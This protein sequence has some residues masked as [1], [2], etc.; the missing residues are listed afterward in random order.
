M[1]VPI[2][3]VKI[4]QP[5]KFV[6]TESTSANVHQRSKG[7]FAIQLSTTVSAL[8]ALMVPVSTPKRDSF[9]TVKPDGLEETALLQSARWRHALM[10]ASVLIPRMVP[11]VSV[12]LVRN[13]TAN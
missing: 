5:V 1:T 10:A 8:L 6:G 9:A 7:G 13:I 4:M 2:I 12:L 3:S 11:V